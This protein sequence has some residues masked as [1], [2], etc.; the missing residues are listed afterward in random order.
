MYKFHLHLEKP[1]DILPPASDPSDVSKDLCLSP[2][3]FKYTCTDIKFNLGLSPLVLLDLTPRTPI[4]P[5]EKIN[6]QTREQLGALE[7]NLWLEIFANLHT[8]DIVALMIASKFFVDIANAPE[9]RANLQNDKDNKTRELI[10][11][12]SY[13]NQPMIPRSIMRNI[14]FFDQ[15]DQLPIQTI[16]PLA[17]VIAEQPGEKGFIMMRG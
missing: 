13:P 5:C 14:G 7:I 8:K 3:H 12:R 17:S 15:L 11:R 1:D 9:I 10:T 2:L 4:L 6:L 16:N